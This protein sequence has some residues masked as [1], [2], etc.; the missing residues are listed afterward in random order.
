MGQGKPVCRGVPSFLT[1][2]ALVRGSHGTTDIVQRSRE[3][4]LF[5]CAESQSTHV[6]PPPKPTKRPYGYWRK[7][8]N[9]LSELR[10]FVRSHGEYPVMPTQSELIAAGRPDLAGAISRYGSWTEVASD[11]GLVLSSIAKPRSLNLVFCTNLRSGGMKPYR[12]WRDFSNLQKE[13]NA[14]IAS[15]CEDQ[16]SRED[17][18]ENVI[19]NV[20]PSAT[21]LKAAGRSDLVR[22][23]QMHGGWGTVAKRMDFYVRGGYWADF[24]NVQFEVERVAKKHMGPDMAGMMPSLKMIREHGTPGLFM[25]VTRR[26]G[27]I[28]KVA[29]RMGLTL[30]ASRRPRGYWASEENL[31]RE[32]MACLEEICD[33]APSRDATLMPSRTELHSIG[34]WDAAAAVDRH[35]GPLQV[36]IRLNLKPPRV[37]SRQKETNL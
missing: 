10:D 8:E 21:V 1:A 17:A 27:G 9:V 31:R 36:A 32:I 30:P 29:K 23:I 26:H 37:N 22:A 16:D 2:L 19:A 28:G 18:C 11:C 25:A 5:T 35:G 15:Q 6:P 34:R 24:A 3:Q 7:R 20:I 13:L 4:L 33:A 12:Y 14:F